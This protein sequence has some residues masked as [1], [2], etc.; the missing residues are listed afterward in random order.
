MWLVLLVPFDGTFT[1]HAGDDGNYGVSS[2]VTDLALV[3]FRIIM[4]PGQMVQGNFY[5]APVAFVTRLFRTLGTVT[6]LREKVGQRGQRH[7]HMMRLVAVALN[8]LEHAPFV[9][10]VQAIQGFKLR[11]PDWHDIAQAWKWKENRYRPMVAVLIM[12][13]INF[14][15]EKAR[16]I[17]GKQQRDMLYDA[18]MRVNPP[19][20]RTASYAVG[21]KGTASE[22]APP[23]AERGPGSVRVEALLEVSGMNL[24]VNPMFI[25]RM[26]NK[27][28]TELH[29][30][31]N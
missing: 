9:W 15:W 17:W 12:A 8:P 10:F 1:Y 29:R 6:T 5:K 4:R 11:P 13:T 7:L 26:G 23:K 19:W 24:P 30:R 28:P 27:V 2:D 31:G 25:L 22:C 16:K 3:V 14:C 20:K 21:I 18:F